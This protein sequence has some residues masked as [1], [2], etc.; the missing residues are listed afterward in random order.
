MEKE[1]ALRRRLDEREDD[2]DRDDGSDV[3][4][5]RDALARKTSENEE[6]LQISS[7]LLQQLERAKAEQSTR[8]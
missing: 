5:L 6:L 3:R 2:C 8:Q 7:D 1:A 4:A